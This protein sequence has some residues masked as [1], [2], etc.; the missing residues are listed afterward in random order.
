MN[1]FESI[2]ESLNKTVKN[3]SEE[4]LIEKKQKR[5]ISP[6]DEKDNEIIRKIISKLKKNK[7][8]NL[9]DEEKDIL[10]KHDIDKYDDTIYTELGSFDTEGNRIEHD[11]VIKGNGE[12]YYGRYPQSDP[13]KVDFVN[14]SRKQKERSKYYKDYFDTDGLRLNVPRVFRGVK[15]KSD[16]GGVFN[17]QSIERATENQKLKGVNNKYK[18]MKRELST[19]KKNAEHVYSKAENDR[20]E[21]LNEIKRLKSILNS[22]DT[23]AEE[24]ANDYLQHAKTVRDDIDSYMNDKRTKLQALKDRKRQKNESLLLEKRYI[25]TPE[26]E[27]DDELLRSL[28]KKIWTGEDDDITDEE[29]DAA[30]R[31]GYSINNYY[32]RLEPKYGSVSA[33]EVTNPYHSVGNTGN[34]RVLDKY[35]RT[36]KLDSEGNRIKEKIPANVNLADLGR[37]RK[38]RDGKLSFGEEGKPEYYRDERRLVHI[39]TYDGNDNTVTSDNTDNFEKVVRRKYNHSLK[40]DYDA[41]NSKV[42]TKNSV[43]QEIPKVY[44]RGEEQR[45]HLIQRIRELK[46]RLNNLDAEIES[47]VEEKRNYVKSH[48]NDINSIL[49]NKRKEI[50]KKREER[51]NGNK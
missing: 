45:S 35:I 25:P 16:P 48:Q 28:I 41:L 19:L 42:E 22:L 2:N 38:E 26:D 3:L 30:D 8:Y 14:M 39:P 46:A 44:D 15:K 37:K 9:S 47:S 17:T 43:L 4:Y 31:N 40:Q 11:R 6:E 12:G 21:I 34:R 51:N 7:Y 18:A 27:K 1:L 5:E 32:S 49:D 33:V 24:R 20:E 13:N 10:S 50:Q 23:D 36:N 29:R